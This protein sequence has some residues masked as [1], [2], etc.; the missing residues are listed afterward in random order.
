[1]SP[2]VFKPS[3]LYLETLVEKSRDYPVIGQKM[4]EFRNFKSANP[5]QP[6]GATDKPF[7]GKG[8][9]GTVI[10]GLRHAH[11]THDIMIVYTI[12]GRNPTEF[13]LYGIFT[14]DE[15]GIGQPANMKRQQSQAK[16]M[17]NQVFTN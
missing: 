10:S 14:H 6:F 11:L 15:L 9:F 17:A 5:L 1:M 4:Q 16:R 12:S 7:V 3:Q 2:V 8:S 13:R